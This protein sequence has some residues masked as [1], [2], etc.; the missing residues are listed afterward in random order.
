MGKGKNL[1]LLEGFWAWKIGW[2]VWFTKEDELCP[3]YFETEMFRILVEVFQEVNWMW[4]L[5]RELFWRETDW[6]L[7]A[8][9]YY[10]KPWPF[11][12]GYVVVVM[13]LH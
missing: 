12:V 2:M 9:R 10:L 4:T 8:L 6:D 7:S 1:G 13:V 3:R 11:V 5:G